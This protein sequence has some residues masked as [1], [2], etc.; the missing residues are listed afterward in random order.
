MKKILI[1]RSVGLDN[2]KIMSILSGIYEINTVS[3]LNEARLAVS[4]HSP[5]AVICGEAF[6]GMS[7]SQLS[8]EIKSGGAKLL[9][10]LP[11]ENTEPFDTIQS[12][13]D[14]VIFTP[15]CEAELL[16]RLN[17]LLYGLEKPKATVFRNANMSID[18][19]NCRIFIDSSPLHL[20]MLEYKLLCLLSKSCGKAVGYNTILR[21]LWHTPIGNEILSLRVFVNAIRKKIRALGDQNNYIQTQTGVGYVMPIL[22]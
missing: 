4:E 5:A 16:T 9:T 3:T 6:S 22:D 17:S 14:D 18:Y 20:T 15:F 7:V 13:S 10:I 12:G 19:E 11:E 21:E 1:C 2:A 8:A